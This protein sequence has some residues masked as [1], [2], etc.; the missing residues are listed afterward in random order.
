M[1]AFF[2]FCTTPEGVY[3]YFNAKERKELKKHNSNNHSSD[4]H[5]SI[6]HRYG[7]IGAYEDTLT[8]WEYNP[9]TKEL[10]LDTK[11][12]TPPCK[13]DVLAY[14]HKLDFQQMAPE[15]IMKKIINPFA[16]APPKEIT[17]E[18]IALVHEWASAADSVWDVLWDTLDASVDAN[19][20]STVVNEVWAV[21]WGD[22]DDSLIY[23]MRAS[24]LDSVRGYT[25]SFFKIEY[26]TDFSSIIKLW[27]MGLVP[28]NDGS[29]WYL[30]SQNGVVWEKKI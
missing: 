21:S 16:I 5:T 28:Y 17:P 1:C 9:L 19:I 30:H 25:T 18:I 6:A 10:K 12:E 2:S 22:M 4:S 20:W 23:P 26:E 29:R 3:L 24:M 14:L 13:R 8:K 27:E 7:Y 11:G 15:L